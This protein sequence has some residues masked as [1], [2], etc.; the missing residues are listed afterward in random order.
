MR[1]EQKRGAVF[2]ASPADALATPLGADDDGLLPALLDLELEVHS[3]LCPLSGLPRH[4]G[5]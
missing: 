3:A 2:T 4:P 1:A 5:A